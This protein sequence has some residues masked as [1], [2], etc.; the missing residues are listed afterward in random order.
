[1]FSPKVRDFSEDQGITETNRNNFDQF[2]NEP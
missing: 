2:S 1:M